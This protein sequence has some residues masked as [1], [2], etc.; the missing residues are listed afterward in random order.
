MNWR[1]L[2]LIICID[3]FSNPHLVAAPNVK[4]CVEQLSTQRSASQ[5]Q[6]LAKSITVKVL[7]KGFLGSGILIKRQDSVYTVL[8]NAHV[9]RA[10]DKTYQ[11]QTPDGQR[12]PASVS[13]LDQALHTASGG[14]NDLALLQFRSPAVTYA[15]ASLGSASTLSV[16][17]EVFAAGFP[18]DAEGI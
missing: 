17:D 7:S 8:T 3:G 11:I 13:K 5:M 1:L 2:M 16:R 10:G 15:V 9:L 18:F 12:Y 6:Q 4:V 14:S